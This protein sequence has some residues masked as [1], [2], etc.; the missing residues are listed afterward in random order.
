MQ[1]GIIWVHVDHDF[2]PYMVSLGHNYHLN[3]IP[4]YEVCRV[5]VLSPGL[6]SVLQ[7]LIHCIREQQIWLKKLFV[8]CMLKLSTLYTELKL[9]Y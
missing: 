8:I 6:G 3:D 7:T 5:E 9:T 1:L 2:R 4:Q